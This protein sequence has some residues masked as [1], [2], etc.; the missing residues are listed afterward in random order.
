MLYADGFV[1]HRNPSPI[2]GGYTV[3]DESGNLVE[4]EAMLK[5]DFT[6][7]E[8]ELL[9]IIRAV[10]LSEHGGKV[11]TDSRT[12]QGWI[13]RGRSKTRRD[14]IP[15]IRQCQTLAVSK[16]VR[17]VHRR[18]SENLAGVY[19]EQHRPNIPPQ[20]DEGT[21]AMKIE[22]ARVDDNSINLVFGP[23]NESMWLMLCIDE[24]EAVALQTQL[25]AFVKGETHEADTANS[26]VLVDLPIYEQ[27]IDHVSIS[28]RNAY[29]EIHSDDAYE[30]WEALSHILHIREG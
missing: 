16:G 3:V 5:S 24:H 20:T 13:T 4:R 6:S 21:F 18:R 12:V 15:S 9:A 8:A 10:E 2:G 29:L 7:N 23:L 14:L 11:V 28:I 17:I 22:V 25:D 19:N 30:L 26:G 1:F 27:E